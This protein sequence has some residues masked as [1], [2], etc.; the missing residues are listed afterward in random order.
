MHNAFILLDEAQNTTPM[1]IKMFLTRM[2]PHSKAII[3]GDMSQVDLPKKQKSGL[4]E[5][6]QILKDIKGI[7]I[8]KLTGEDVVRHRLVK[9]I[10]EAYD[11][12]DALIEKEQK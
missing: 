5:S 4:I 1:Q 11:K 9:H 3:T 6:T 7:G 10:I 2:G 12:N 8:I